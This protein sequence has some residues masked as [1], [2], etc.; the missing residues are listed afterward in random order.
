MSEKIKIFAIENY[1]I[2]PHLWIPLKPRKWNT[3]YPTGF[4]QN[5]GYLTISGA[6][7]PKTFKKLQD[8]NFHRALTEN[9]EPLRLTQGFYPNYEDAVKSKVDRGFKLVGEIDSRWLSIKVITK[10]NRS[11][12]ITYTEEDLN[13]AFVNGFKYVSLETVLSLEDTSSHFGV[14]EPLWA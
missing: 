12:L 5:I 8:N 2:D 11:K 9:A 4:N 14:Q 6:I 10:A 13:W 3:A 1:T 7:H